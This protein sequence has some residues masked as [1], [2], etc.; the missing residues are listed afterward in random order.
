[1]DAYFTLALINLLAHLFYPPFRDRGVELFV[2]LVQTVVFAGATCSLIKVQMMPEHGETPEQHHLQEIFG[3][4][5]NCFCALMMLIYWA[6]NCVTQRKQ[7]KRRN[8]A[9]AED[10]DNFMDLDESVPFNSQRT[11]VASMAAA[12]VGAEG[13]AVAMVQEDLEVQ[14]SVSAALW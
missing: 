1:M 6:F 2:V 10:G 13:L 5:F 12:G 14:T 4:G 9:A 3:I 8:S 11:Q 7:S